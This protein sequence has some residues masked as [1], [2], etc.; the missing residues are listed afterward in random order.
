MNEE[1]HLD[2]SEI[3]FKSVL[4]KEAFID[5]IFSGEY[6]D[7]YFTEDIGL[8]KENEDGEETEEYKIWLYLEDK[9]E[10]LYDLWF[11][12][13]DPYEIFQAYWHEEGATSIFWNHSIERSSAIDNFKNRPELMRDFRILELGL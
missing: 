7:T 1:T 8:D 5:S 2:G 4:T 12:E 11:S 9:H 13:M 10:V 3:V 6:W